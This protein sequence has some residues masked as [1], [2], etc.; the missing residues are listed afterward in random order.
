MLR[1]GGGYST[2]CYYWR[3]SNFEDPPALLRPQRIRRK[4]NCAGEKNH[5]FAALAWVTRSVT[6]DGREETLNIAGFRE[7]GAEN[8][9][10][11]RAQS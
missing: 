8:V 6:T 7:L 11:F 9:R 2:G 4:R 10:F 1:E 5:K 3:L